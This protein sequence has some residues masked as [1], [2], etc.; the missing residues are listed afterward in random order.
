MAE[1]G[2]KGQA[3]FRQRDMSCSEE[4]LSPL[5]IKKFAVFA[6]RLKTRLAA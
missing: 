4:N 1:F 2:M 3:L 5:P 6:A